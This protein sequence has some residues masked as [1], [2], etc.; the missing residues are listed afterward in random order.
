MSEFPEMI[1][2]RTAA[3]RTGLSY[4]FLRKACITG[5]IVYIRAGKKFLLNAEALQEY[6]TK[7]EQK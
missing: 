1:S 4:D 7:G 3:D 5:R 6:L 2:L